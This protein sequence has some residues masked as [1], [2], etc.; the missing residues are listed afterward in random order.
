MNQP[1]RQEIVKVASLILI[2]AVIPDDLLKRPELLQQHFVLMVVSGPFRRTKALQQRFLDPNLPVG[3]IVEFIE[4]SVKQR[5]IVTL[6]QHLVQM[7]KKLDQP[8]VL[9][10]AEPG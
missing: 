4:V 10:A 8:V 5:R 7:L 1:L 9:E 3:K 2:P 6:E